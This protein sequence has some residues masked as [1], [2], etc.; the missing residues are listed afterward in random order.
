MLIKVTI[1]RKSNNTFSYSETE[2]LHIIAAPPIQFFVPRANLFHPSL[3]TQLTKKL[4]KPSPD[5]WNSA[6]AMSSPVLC[7]GTQRSEIQEK[8]E[9]QNSEYSVNTW[10]KLCVILIFLRYNWWGFLKVTEILINVT[11]V[12]SEFWISSLLFCSATPNIP[13][14]AENLDEFSFSFTSEKVHLFL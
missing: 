13:P 5:W 9:N 8:M 7:R 10:A 3:E 2:I 11:G 1:F 6:W 12:L 14:F 4:I